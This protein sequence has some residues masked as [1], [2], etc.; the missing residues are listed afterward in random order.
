MAERTRIMGIDPGD[1]RI[2]I[3][4]SDPLA[5]IANGI[6]TIRWNG[7]D[8]NKAEERICAIVA[9][10]GVAEIVVGLPRRTD[11]RPGPAEEK[12]RSLADALSHRL[13]IPVLLQDERYTS[14]LASRILRETGASRDRKG[15]AVDRMAAAILLQDYLERRRK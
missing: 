5:M 4:V 8:R 15:G 9:E 12:S 3:A 1:A 2:G 11:G 7:V 10:Q 13:G 14:V 6:E